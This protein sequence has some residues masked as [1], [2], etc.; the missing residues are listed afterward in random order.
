[1]RKALALGQGFGKIKPRWNAGWSSLV[2]R[3]AHNLEV[4]G[5]NP[6]PATN[7]VCLGRKGLP[8][9]F[10]IRLA[11]RMVTT[12]GIMPEPSGPW[13]TQTARHLMDSFDGFLRGCRYLFHDRSPVFTEEFELMLQS[14]GI[15]SVRLPPRSPN[16]KAYA[17]RFVR[18]IKA[19]CLDRMP[20]I[21]E[22]SLQRAVSQFVIHYHTER[23]H[24][25][26][27][28]KTVRP[29]FP[30]FPSEGDVCCR[31]R[32]AGL[33]RYYY[34]EAARNRVRLCF[35]TLRGGYGTNCRA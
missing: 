17:E 6:A 22:S 35:W 3:K 10:V 27:E 7:L 9:W 21:G 13:M 23:N 31:K 33:L 11:S 12:A 15:Q 20:L 18:S 34:R 32:L 8:H 5:S 28:D 16:L 1:M 4:A 19:A 30:V 29:E 14:A 26:L 2:A 24:Q 25:G